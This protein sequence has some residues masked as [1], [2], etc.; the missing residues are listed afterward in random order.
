A[1]VKVCPI[2]GDAFDANVRT[3]ADMMRANADSL[4]KCLK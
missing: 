2:Y 3:Y 4:A 1:H